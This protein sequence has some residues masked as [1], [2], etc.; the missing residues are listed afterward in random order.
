M[1]VNTFISLRFKL[2]CFRYLQVPLTHW[3]REFTLLDGYDE[4]NRFMSFIDQGIVSSLQNI[5]QLKQNVT[6]CSETTVWWWSKWT[7]FV[8]LWVKP[9][10][11]LNVDLNLGNARL[12]PQSHGQVPEFDKFC[13][14]MK[15]L[16]AGC[17]NECLWYYRDF[18]C[19][20]TQIFTYG[21]AIWASIWS[22]SSKIATTIISF[23]HTSEETYQPLCPDIFCEIA[24]TSLEILIQP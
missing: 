5:G 13:N 14:M 20:L 15:I 12:V 18:G 9:I 7:K 4:S 23:Q 17:N 8:N 3:S 2:F 1:V 24:A 22:S 10:Q 11:K 21:A 19:W 16:V 6:K